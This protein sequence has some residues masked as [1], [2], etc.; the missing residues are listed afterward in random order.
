MQ[1]LFFTEEVGEGRCMYRGYPSAQSAERG[2]TTQIWHATLVDGRQGRE[3]IEVLWVEDV[4]GDEPYWV[5]FLR[6]LE[7]FM[8]DVREMSANSAS[9][10]PK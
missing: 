8:P 6:R 10:K 5:R 1:L 3:Y 2:Q 7:E 9:N 4:A